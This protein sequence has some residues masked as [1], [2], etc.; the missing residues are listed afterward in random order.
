MVQIFREGAVRIVK[1][2]REECRSR[3][4]PS[5]KEHKDSGDLKD[6]PQGRGQP[7]LLIRRLLVDH[8]RPVGSQFERQYPA[9]QSADEDVA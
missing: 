4:S 2:T 8:I 7:Y 1:V 5:G 3:L 9:L 6:I